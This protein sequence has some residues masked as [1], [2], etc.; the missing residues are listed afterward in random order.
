MNHLLTIDVLQGRDL[1]SKDVSGFSDPFCKVMYFSEGTHFVDGVDP[2]ELKSVWSEQQEQER[3]T[4]GMGS[5]ESTRSQDDARA[6]DEEEAA[7]AA[8]AE[9][10][11]AATGAG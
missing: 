4:L 6:A 8:A 10:A 3:Q 9:A 1:A 2:E 7:A 5:P 11:E